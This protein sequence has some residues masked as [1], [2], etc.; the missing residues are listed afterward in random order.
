MVELYERAFYSKRPGWDQVASFIYNDLCPC[1][2][3]RKSLED[4]QFHLVKI[5]IFIKMKREDTRNQLV[6]KLQAPGG[7]LW[8]EYGVYVRGY[9]LD[10]NVKVIRLLGVSPESN[11]EDI[12]KTLKEVGIGDVID[13]V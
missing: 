10:A 12:I 8:S 7:V 2:D 6:K 9:C 13:R 5:I 4:V 3:L 11:A 1:D